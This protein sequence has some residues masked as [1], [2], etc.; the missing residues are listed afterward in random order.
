M[1]LSVITACYN[2]EATLRYTLDSFLSQ[3]HPKKEIIIIDGMS[4]DK[5]VEI[6]ESYRSSSIRVF[7]EA[8]SGVFDAMNKGFRL[9]EGDGIGWLN[10][11]DT[12]HDEFALARVAEA[13]ENA[14]AAFGDLLM[15]SDH[16]SKE[17]VREWKAGPFTAGAFQNGWQPPHPG[18]F[19]RRELAERVGLYDL[20]YRTAADYDWM[21]R[22]LHAA[23]VTAAYVPHVLTDFKMGGI[24][25]RDWRA[26]LN[27]TLECLRS[28]RAHL[29][30]PPL[31]RAVFLRIWRRLFQIRKLSSYYGGGS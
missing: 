26:T 8:D 14:D 23:G 19:A 22:A 1:R 9:F 28:R 11:D 7:S 15:V 10:S 21:L 3:T 18:F 24:S 13:L 6:A 5:T 17:V 20:S 4:K 27:G 16:E 30:A 29:G 31:D 2:S 12:F 25:T